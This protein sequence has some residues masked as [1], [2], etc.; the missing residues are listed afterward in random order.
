MSA[1]LQTKSASA[2][3]NVCSWL[4]AVH[5]RAEPLCNVVDEVCS[6][7]DEVRELG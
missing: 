1:R 2:Q 5:A 4:D 3:R 7:A 6:L